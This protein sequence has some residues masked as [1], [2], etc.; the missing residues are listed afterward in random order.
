MPQSGASLDD[1]DWMLTSFRGLEGG[2]IFFRLF[3]GRGESSKQFEFQ[4]FWRNFFVFC[5]ASLSFWS[6]WSQLEHGMENTWNYLGQHSWSCH[7]LRNASQNSHNPDTKK[8]KWVD[9][10]VPR[11][12]ILCTYIYIY[13]L[14][15]HIYIHTGSTNPYP[16]TV[17]GF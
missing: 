10:R 9:H 3:G 8:L 14:N 17:E 4:V 7:G 15:I 2:G 12:S 13:I 1:L 16:A 6:F 11:K 5:F